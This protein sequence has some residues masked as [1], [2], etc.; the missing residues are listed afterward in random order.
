[1]N[2]VESIIFNALA[3]R[4]TLWL[5]EA[6]TLG[7]VLQPA[8]AEGKGR[9]RPP[10]NKV[11]FSA[12]EAADAVSVVALMEQEDIADADNVYR[13][14][15]D[16]ARKGKNIAID[17]VGE[18]K[19]GFFTPS[20]QLNAL[21]NPALES[22]SLKAGDKWKDVLVLVV[23]FAILLGG[24]GYWWWK[25][26]YAGGT[27]S[28]NRI[29]ATQQA[30]G[31]SGAE[32]A[33][34]SEAVTGATLTDAVAPDSIPQAT[35]TTQA[36]SIEESPEAS[37]AAENR[38]AETASQQ[39]AGSAETNI[40]PRYYIVGGV[41]S[42]DE[43]AEKYIAKMRKRFPDVGYEKVAFPGGKVMVSFFSSSDSD[44]ANRMRKQLGR[45]MNNGDLWIHKA[46]K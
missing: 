39:A 9:L 8:R 31:V 7:V 42:V 13:K 15:L 40:F 27:D 35:D 44:E 20:P 25:T 34:G 11:E 45:Q 23:V 38:S 1:M 3:S 28:G 43:N 22:V 26:Q 30:Q 41:F 37:S 17:G 10:F 16:G 21:L 6:G 4:R 24:V 32:N 29:A 18:L 2:S 19:A 46:V 12:K 36:G 14:W 33:G 5:P